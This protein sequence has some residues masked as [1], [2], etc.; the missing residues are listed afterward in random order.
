MER[1]YNF[2]DKVTDLIIGPLILLL[3]ALAMFYLVG[4]AMNLIL[5]ADEPE[6]RKK[7]RQVL[8]WGIVGIF[9]MVTAITI[10]RVVTATFCETEFCMNP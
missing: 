3:F 2:I 1:L 5:K 8:I 7:G 4:G 6:A 10:L 9:I